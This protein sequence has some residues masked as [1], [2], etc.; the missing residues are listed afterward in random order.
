MPDA[1]PQR[2]KPFL[3]FQGKAEAALKFYVETV[4]DSAISLLQ[5]HPEGGPAAGQVLR[6]EASIGGQPVIVFD[7]PVEHA[8]DFTPR[9]S[10]F[11]EA[12]DEAEI[13]RIYAALL[14]GGQALMPIGDYGF[15]RRFGWVNDR[16][17]VSWQINLA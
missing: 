15:S 13:E 17:G 1:A 2:V 7:S 14:D 12:K 8:F 11:V 10:F 3:M 4:P 6:G 16:F 5:H 9:W